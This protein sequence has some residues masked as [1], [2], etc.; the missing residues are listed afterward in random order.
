MG[1]YNGGRL[2]IE[3]T[4]G[5]H[6]P[7]KRAKLRMTVEGNEELTVRRRVDLLTLELEKS[8]F[9]LK[10]V[11][12]QAKYICRFATESREHHETFSRECV[13]KHEGCAPICLMNGHV[14]F[15]RLS[16]SNQGMVTDLRDQ[17][18]RHKQQFRDKVCVKL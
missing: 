17:V 9:E 12:E 14:L 8:Q 7:P 6:P 13:M 15:D 5:R 1:R 4:D 11:T 18:V 3:S 10:T 2:W 16:K